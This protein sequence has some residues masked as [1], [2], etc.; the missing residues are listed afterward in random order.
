MKS[1][2]PI[3]VLAIALILCCGCANTSPSAEESGAAISDTAISGPGEG[4]VS[5][6]Y[7]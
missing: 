1:F 6:S 7:P 4:D 2:L 3:L 5:I